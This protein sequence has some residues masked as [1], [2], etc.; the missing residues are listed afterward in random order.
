MTLSVMPREFF[1]AEFD[2]G[3]YRLRSVR[4]A[5][6]R[7]RERVRHADRYL[8]AFQANANRVT[9]ADEMVADVNSLKR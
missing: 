9:R 8:R 4:G 3:R 6:R 1:A 2:I 5:E 7:P